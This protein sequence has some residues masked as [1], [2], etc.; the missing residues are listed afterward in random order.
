MSRLR[1]FLQS[2]QGVIAVASLAAIAASLI[3]SAA[4]ASETVRN[5]PLVAVVVIGGIPLVWE[6]A[7]DLI[8]RNPGAD[9]LAALA[10][11]TAVLLD[12]WLVA[13]IIVLMLSGGEALEEA[14]TA[15]A[16]RVLEALAKRAPTMAHVFTEGDQTT[17]VNVADIQV[18]DPILVLPHEVCPVDGQV[19]S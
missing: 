6:I 12:E 3:L 13:A 19:V 14:A 10:I 5:A 16:S 8:A 2:R 18:G 4:G 15:R 7:K 17:E 9:L 1:L 11:V